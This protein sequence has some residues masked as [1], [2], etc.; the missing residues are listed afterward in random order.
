MNAIVFDLYGTLLR[1]REPL[2]HK[3][4][5][6]RLG[7][8]AKPWIRLV[9]SRLMTSS[10][11]DR[12]AF[13]RCVIDS[14][15]PATSEATAAACLE[16]VERELASIEVVDGVHTLLTFLGRRGFRLG[17]LSNLSSVHKEALTR[18]D[19]A[20]HFSAMRLSCDDGRVKPEPEIYLDL[21]RDL[22]APPDSVLMIGDSL[23]NDVLAP[24]SL[25]MAALQIAPTSENGALES[26]LAFGWRSF[27]TEARPL[28]RDGASIALGGRRG[29]LRNI[30][31][32]PESHQGRLN[33][34]ATA[35]LESS[36]TAPRVFAKRF[37]FP[38]AAYVEEFMHRL[39]AEIGL[40]TCDAVVVDGPEP[41][42]VVST[43]PGARFVDPVDPPLAFELGRHSAAAYLFAN[44]DLRPRNTFV[45]REGPQPVVTLID[46]EHCLFNLALDVS[47]LDD[48]LSPTT[49]DRLPPAEI[50]RRIKR[51]VLTERTTRRAMGTFLELESLDSE[52]AR[53]FR[54]GW[55]DTFRAVQARQDALCALIEERI[56]TSPHLVIGTQS[57]RRAMA[58]LDLEDMRE[59]F[60]QDPEELFPRMAAVRSGPAR[61][62]NHDA[63]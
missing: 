6:R 18:F 36:G 15:A 7:V 11:P 63:D 29:V 19:L 5:P 35:N 53:A 62:S 21:C 60:L 40:P 27:D 56:Y 1:I 30:V 45:L 41:V 24:R 59:R 4:L 58:R 33:L 9:R 2:I 23:S 37:L 14:L 34:A 44:A 49:F 16:I 12:E 39:M 32:L 20:R 52:L 43:A 22:D 55:V 38:E 50:Q 31:S 8:G 10:F 61:S 51:R 25:G 42:L 28:L 3:E 13:V 54:R 47:E 17:L 48:T 46:L 57:Y 26:L